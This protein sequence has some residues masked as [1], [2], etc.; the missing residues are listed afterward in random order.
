MAA[1]KTQ[2]T[3]ASARAF[4]K[5]VT[6][7]EKSDD[8]LELLLMFEDITGEPARMWGSAI[9]GFGK[10][11]YESTRSAQ[12][13]D[14]PLTAF[15]PRKQNITIYIMPGFKE[16]GDLME[17]LGDVKK[18]VSCL[19]IKSLNDIHIPTLKKLIDRSVKDMRKK[20]PKK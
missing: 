18:S 20:Y 16:Y 12:K 19:Y 5:K 10:Y 8:C 1:I 15:S 7:K 4:I 13:G 3:K 2:M 11:H 9:V 14:W 17:K 6:P